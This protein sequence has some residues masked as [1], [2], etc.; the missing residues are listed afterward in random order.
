MSVCVSRIAWPAKCPGDLAHRTFIPTLNSLRDGILPWANDTMAEKKTF[1]SWE[2]LGSLVYSTGEVAPAGGG[3]ARA[4]DDR[5]FAAASDGAPGRFRQKR[6][7]DDAGGGFPGRTGGFGGAGRSAQTLLRYRRVGQGCD[8]A[9]PGR[10]AAKG[11]RVSQRTGLQ[12][13]GAVRRARTLAAAR[14]GWKIVKM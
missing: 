6:Q 13:P 14:R 2:A 1:S 5:T 8:G 10:C 9:H 7:G 11:R 4:G 12:S 3:T